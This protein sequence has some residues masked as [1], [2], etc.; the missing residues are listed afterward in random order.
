MNYKNIKDLKD[1]STEESIFIVRVGVNVPITNGKIENDFRL[2]KILPTINFLIEKKAKIVLIGHLGRKKDNSLKL[3]FEWLKSNLKTKVY[4]D[5]KTF[6]DFNNKKVSGKIT[7]LKSGQVLLLDNIRATDQEKENSLELAKDISKLGDFYINE[8]FSVS[9]R[10]HMSV[11]QL[12]KSFPEEKVFFGIQY[13]K[14]I[15]NIEKIKSNQK[16]RSIFILGGSKVS[17]KI[18]MMEKMIEKFDFIILGGAVANQFY[19]KLGYEIGQSLIEQDFLFNQSSFEKIINSSKVFLP[20][21]IVTQNGEKEVSK[22]EKND[23]ILDISPSS[24]TDIKKIKEA[25]FVFFNGPVGFYEEGYKEGTKFLL[26]SL[27]NKNNYFVAGG[28]NTISAIF[29]LNLE[30]SI[31]F[32]S[33]GG[34]ALIEKLSK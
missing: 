2:K 14:E 12:P 9:H 6:L 28:G 5:Q 10:K 26:E 21:I 1:K 34:G 13:Q 11:D 17:T 3:I 33:T 16:E 24:F 18:P 25:Q 20:N 4:F 23:K 30:Q 19:K 22:V 15:E 8:A 32:I 31:D 29:E 7:E 27:A